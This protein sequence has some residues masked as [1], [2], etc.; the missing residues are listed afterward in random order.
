MYISNSMT[1]HAAH[2][3]LYHACVHACIMHDL[4]IVNQ[5]PLNLNSLGQ[6]GL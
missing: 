1:A 5:S 3:M 6:R 4:A 2:V